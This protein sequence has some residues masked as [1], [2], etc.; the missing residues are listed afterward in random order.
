MASPN[1]VNFPQPSVRPVSKVQ[2]ILAL[3]KE[4]DLVREMGKFEDAIY[5]AGAPLL[6]LLAQDVRSTDVVSLLDHMTEVERW[7]ERTSRWHAL[8]KCFLEHCKSD[9]FI[10]I[11]TKGVTDFERTAYQKR[12]SA[13]FAGLETWLEGVVDSIDSRVNL[14]KKLA[15][16]D[17][18]GSRSTRFS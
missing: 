13:G 18:A 14:C 2:Q 12:L 8:A 17:E 3:V 9:H 10:V 15:G 7:R 1:V 5:E 11:R 4:E 16:L 6:R